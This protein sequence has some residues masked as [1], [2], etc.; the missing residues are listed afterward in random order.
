[1]TDIFM[2]TVALQ[3]TWLFSFVVVL[4]SAFCKELRP[5]YFQAL[6]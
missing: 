2:K 4:E 1:M 6:A 3:K 5:K